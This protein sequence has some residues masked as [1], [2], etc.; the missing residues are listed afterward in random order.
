MFGNSLIHFATSYAVFWDTD[1]LHSRTVCMMP[2][3]HPA[4]LWA[5]SSRNLFE[6]NEKNN[7]V[8]CQSS[9]DSYL[10]SIS[11][12]HVSEEKGCLLNQKIT[13]VDQRVRESSLAHTSHPLADFGAGPH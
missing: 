7:L 4:S 13:F 3:E 10:Y 11:P 9:W 2:R 5:K 8:K 6:R 1:I 12:S